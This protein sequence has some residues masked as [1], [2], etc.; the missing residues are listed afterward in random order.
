MLSQGQSCW[1]SD[2]P[3]QCTGG[4]GGAWASGIKGNR[5]HVFIFRVV[6]L[7]GSEGGVIAT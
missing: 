6:K 2:T 4:A 5:A 3:T 7:K 1:T